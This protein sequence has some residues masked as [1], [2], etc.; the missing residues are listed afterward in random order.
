MDVPEHELRAARE[1][2]GLNA[3]GDPPA[4]PTIGGPADPAQVAQMQATLAALREWRASL[5]A[6]P[7]LALPQ[8]P[9]RVR[10]LQ[11][12]DSGFDFRRWGLGLSAAASLLVVAAGMWTVAQLG[13]KADPPDL[14][15]ALS[16]DPPQPLEMAPPP[17][18]AIAEDGGLTGGSPAETAP[19]AAPPAP[20]LDTRWLALAPAWPAGKGGRGGI[21]DTEGGPGGVPDKGTIGAP[22]GTKSGADVPKTQGGGQTDGGGG[23]TFGHAEVDLKVEE[24][25]KIERLPFRCRVANELPGGWKLG[26]TRSVGP[27]L[28]VRYLRG[29]EVLIVSVWQQPGIASADAG[30]API[31]PQRKA[32]VLV[33]GGLG[34]AFEGPVS[35]AEASEL[36]PQ[37]DI[38]TV[39]P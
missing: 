30:E 14:A 10:D 35:A 15:Q 36:T 26:G 2:L 13:G 3:A 37:F 16:Q 27:R 34:F 32:I 20:S 31:A 11:P 22:G 19:M 24:P 29:R 25:A 21:G 38:R 4:D 8:T 9:A 23:G 28:Q 6:E 18:G 7:P 17:A 1:A 39:R 33:R 12:G 5:E